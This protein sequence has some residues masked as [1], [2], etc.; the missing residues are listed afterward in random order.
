M[1]ISAVVSSRDQVQQEPQPL[2]HGEV[3][4][5]GADR[6]QRYGGADE[7]VGPAALALVQAGR[8]ER[9]HLVQ[10]DWRGQD[11]ADRDRDLQ[12]QE[13]R[14]PQA[15]HVQL[16]ALVQHERPEAPRLRDLAIRGLDEAP[17]LRVDKP[18][19]DR[20]NGQRDRCLDDAVAKL[21]QMIQQRHP[22]LWIGPPREPEI[23]LQVRTQPIVYHDRLGRPL[24]RLAG[25][26]L[27][28]LAVA[29]A[30][31]LPLQLLYLLLEVC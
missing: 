10:P 21:T 7:V 12:P 27:G 22:C 19:D 2:G 15:S 8:D 17:D 23:P 13:E 16:A 30:G 31:R 24:D 26:R 28:W 25:L 9:P 29:A 6:E 4:D 1:V 18:A 5:R 20:A 14:V 3:G 11:D